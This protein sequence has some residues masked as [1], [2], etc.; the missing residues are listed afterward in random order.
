[1]SKTL[2]WMKAWEAH[3]NWCKHLY[4]RELKKDVA[5]KAT[6]QVEYTDTSNLCSNVKYVHVERE[7]QRNFFI[8]ADDQMKAIKRKQQRRRNDLLVFVF[9]TTGC[10]CCWESTRIS[11]CLTGSISL[12]VA[13][14]KEH[15]C[16]T[17]KKK[18]IWNGPT[19]FN[20][21]VNSRIT[22]AK[23]FKILMGCSGLLSKVDFQRF[24][25]QRCY[26]IFLLLGS[27]IQPPTF[28]LAQD[29]LVWQP[30]KNV[31]LK[32]SPYCLANTCFTLVMRRIC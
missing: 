32:D 30:S 17:K 1:M 10:E 7:N 28:P 25:L 15:M 12:V 26:V 19:L 14:G 21:L 18:K 16:S 29:A 11:L 3:T 2:R 13:A 20:S 6:A 4:M 8:C 5:T 23:H 22:T 27:F 9:G 24:P 31:Q